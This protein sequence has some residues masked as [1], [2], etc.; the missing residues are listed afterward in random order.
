MRNRLIV[1]AALFGA[2][3]LSVAEGGD[4]SRPDAEA[5]AA[6]PADAEP[7]V[8]EKP[9]GVEATQGEAEPAPAGGE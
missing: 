9:T 3:G 7:T 2:V 1:A 6:E 4:A 5:A 8:W